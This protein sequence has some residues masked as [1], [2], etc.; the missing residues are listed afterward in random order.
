M[1]TATINVA[2]FPQP[3]WSNTSSNGIIRELV[4]ETNF[5]AR[6]ELEESGTGRPDI[7][8][9]THAIRGGRAII[10]E[11]KTVKDFHQIED[12][13]RAALKQIEERDYAASLQA[14]GYHDILQY[15]ISFYRKECMVMAEDL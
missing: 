1:K 13:C 2:A 10:L 3:Y 15:G 8:M 11:L 5:A 9:K 12:A 14:E 6:E 7:L 4:E